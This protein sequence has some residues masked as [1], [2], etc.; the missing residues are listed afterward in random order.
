MFYDDLIVF[1]LLHEMRGNKQGG[2]RESERQGPPIRMVWWLEYNKLTTPFYMLTMNLFSFA[3]RWKK[4]ENAS[5]YNCVFKSILVNIYI[6][7][8]SESRTHVSVCSERDA[9]L[10]IVVELFVQLYSP[11]KVKTQTEGKKLDFMTLA[12]A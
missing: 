3:C 8:P 6:P 1:P 4:R 10:Y 9:Y 12:P 2:E 11:T 7:L 5:Q